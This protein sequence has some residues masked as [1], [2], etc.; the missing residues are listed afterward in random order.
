MFTMNTT[1]APSTT[2]GKKH[3]CPSKLKGRPP[4]RQKVSAS[5][6]AIGKM[7]PCLFPVTIT[8]GKYAGKNCI[9]LEHLPHRVR[10]QIVGSSLITCIS[11]RS[12]GLDEKKTVWHTQPRRSPRISAMMEAS[13][14]SQALGAD[15]P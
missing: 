15:S 11:R 10:V 2:I 5:P 8:G 12:L 4:K 14:T 1:S 7:H 9:I 6:T 3:S 13:R